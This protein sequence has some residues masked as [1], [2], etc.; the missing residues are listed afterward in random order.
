MDCPL[1]GSGIVGKCLL[2]CVRHLAGHLH[3]RLAV[4]AA[5]IGGIEALWAMWTGGP[6]DDLRACWMAPQLLSRV[7]SLRSRSRASSQRS[8]ARFP[9]GSRL[10]NVWYNTLGIPVRMFE[11][12]FVH[13]SENSLR[14]FRNCEMFANFEHVEHFFVK[15]FWDLFAQY[16]YNSC[17]N[18]RNSRLWFCS[19]ISAETPP[20][21]GPGER[22]RRGPGGGPWRRR[23]SHMAAT[24]SC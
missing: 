11:I 4:D 10:Q 13:I 8:W 20:P 14:G 22:S 1:I 5:R 18:S 7:V 9:P 6:E 21:Q 24:P 16:P 19:H 17:P 15:Q 3:I 12:M 2:G 23:F